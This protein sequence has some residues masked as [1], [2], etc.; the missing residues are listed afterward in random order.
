MINIRNLY[1]MIILMSKY[2]YMIQN[3]Y[4]ST[5]ESMKFKS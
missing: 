5:D 3:D 4:T 1:K 2:D